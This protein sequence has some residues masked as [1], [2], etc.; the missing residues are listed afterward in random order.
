[1]SNPH[2]F[3]YSILS[4]ACLPV[5]PPERYT[6]NMLPRR[7]DSLHIRDTV[8]AMTADQL[9]VALTGATGLVGTALTQHLRGD[10]HRVTPVTRRPDTDGAIFWD[11]SNGRLDPDALAGVDAV[12]HLAGEPL[13]AR[14]WT[15]EQK[16]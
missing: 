13:G 3:R 12:V 11:P 15:T 9:H 1:D 10:G 6:C 4:A 7:V 14:R 2:T 8:R 5:P 16:R